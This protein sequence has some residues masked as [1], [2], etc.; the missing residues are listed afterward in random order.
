MTQVDQ[1]R[2]DLFLVLPCYCESQRLPGFLPSL[3]EE[4]AAS[5][6]SVRVQVVDD[7]SPV[8]ESSAVKSLVES[9]KVDFSFLETPLLLK[10]NQGKGGA[11]RSGWDLGG[12]SDELAFVDA[13][14]AVPAPEV[15]R[16]LERVSAQADSKRIHLAVR[17][18]QDGREL[19]R[20]ISRKIVAKLFNWLIHFR[21]NIQL[22]D[23][24]CGLKTVPGSFY[25]ST[26]DGLIQ[27]GY[28]FDLELILAAD[29]S[30]LS[31]E[32][33][34]VDWKEVPGGSTNLKDGLTF[35]KQLIKHSV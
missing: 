8:E 28:A 5:D 22:S 20:T 35:L 15:V 6:L 30:G 32:T 19:K 18:L 25:R 13:D 31:I 24:Q 11:I 9:L 27:N 10:E 3:C 12:E 21:Y 17:S 34:P 4:I 2:A 29:R 16:F 1:S 26:K 23:T 7:G 14:G 33:I